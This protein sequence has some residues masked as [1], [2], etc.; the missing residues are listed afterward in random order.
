MYNLIEQC[1][2]GWKVAPFTA[3]LV[4]NMPCFYHEIFF[5]IGTRVLHKNEKSVTLSILSVPIRQSTL[6]FLT[7]G[8]RLVWAD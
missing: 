3:K 6:C 4:S 2:S 1:N 7:T 8:D 5:A